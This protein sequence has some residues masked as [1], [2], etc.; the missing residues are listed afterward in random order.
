MEIVLQDVPFKMEADSR[1]AYFLI[2]EE[3]FSFLWPHNAPSIAPCDIQLVV[4]KKQVVDVK[5]ACI[6]SPW[7]FLIKNL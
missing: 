4:Y 6:E 3:T 7:N 5:C 1:C 2:L